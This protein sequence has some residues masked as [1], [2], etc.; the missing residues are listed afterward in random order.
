MAAL[1]YSCLE[2][3][4]D[5]GAW[6]A[7]VHGIAKGWNDWCDLAHADVAMELPEVPG[8]Y[9]NWPT[10]TDRKVCR[11]PCVAV[12]CSGPQSCPT[13]CDPLD[14]SPPGFPVLHSSGACSDS[15]P[16]S[17]WCHP[18]ISSFVAPSPP[19]LNLSQHQGFFQCAG[20]SHQVA[21]VLELQL[22]HQS[23]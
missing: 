8:R 17:R 4:L 3:P 1:Q 19:A 10:A 22:Q 23:L 18:T 16:L 9:Y 14:C 11:R 13:L 5:R 21:R 6:R 2:N 12:C 20:S 15:S 7:T